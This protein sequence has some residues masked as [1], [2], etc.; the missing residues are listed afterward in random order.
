MGLMAAKW[1]H[2]GSTLVSFLI[3]CAEVRGEAPW[4]W[5]TLLKATG[6]FAKDSVCSQR[7]HWSFIWDLASS[8]AV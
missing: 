6:E 7:D 1:L 8:R 4:W 2:W 5:Y 3:L